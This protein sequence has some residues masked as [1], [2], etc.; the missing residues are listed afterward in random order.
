MPVGTGIKGSLFVGKE[1]K[2][3]YFVKLFDEIAGDFYEVPLGD[4]DSMATA[5]AVAEYCYGHN[6]AG[7]FLV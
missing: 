1:I 5:Q 3:T 7:V 6:V 4:F 2:M